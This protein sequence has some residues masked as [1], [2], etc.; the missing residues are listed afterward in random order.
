MSISFFI[1][2]LVMDT[3]EEMNDKGDKDRSL[4]HCS[5][6]SFHMSPLFLVPA[7]LL[8]SCSGRSRLFRLFFSTPKEK[9]DAELQQKARFFFRSRR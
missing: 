5:R 7:L 4:P 2:L 9:P 8:S 3:K 1:A 6:P